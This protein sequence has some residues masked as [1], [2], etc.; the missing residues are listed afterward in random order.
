M[1]KECHA[2]PAAHA[3]RSS[4][5]LVRKRR[6]YF[7][8]IEAGRKVLL[9]NCCRKG[10][11]SSEF[12]SSAVATGAFTASRRR[13]DRQETRWTRAFGSR[14]RIL[15]PAIYER[16][17]PRL[18]GFCLVDGGASTR[19]DARR[20]RRAYQCDVALRGSSRPFGFSSS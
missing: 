18:P 5:N 16:R 3:A 4:S 15:H 14:N 8:A 10:S 11:A 6:S 2:L 9:L 13:R 20:N 1:N 7:S 12:R 17:D 19:N